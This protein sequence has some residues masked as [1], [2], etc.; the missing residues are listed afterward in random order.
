MQSWIL[1]PK[2][3]TNINNFSATTP[4]NIGISL[5]FLAPYVNISYRLPL[6]WINKSCREFERKLFT[7]FFVLRNLK[8]ATVKCMMTNIQ[9]FDFLLDRVTPSFLIN[10]FPFVLGRI[11]PF[12]SMQCRH[13]NLEG[14]ASLGTRYCIWLC[15]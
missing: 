7:Y 5:T 11:N 2:L 1:N 9:W 3:G 12:S 4:K 13:V 15:L 6:D 10:P 14:M 8:V